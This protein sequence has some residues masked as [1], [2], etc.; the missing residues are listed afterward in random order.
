MLSNVVRCSIEENVDFF[1]PPRMYRVCNLYINTVRGVRKKDADQ[2][3][4]QF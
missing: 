1:S 2:I 4:W 3:L